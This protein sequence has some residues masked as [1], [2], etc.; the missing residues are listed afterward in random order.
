V[1][2]NFSKKVIIEEIMETL[3]IEKHCFYSINHMPPYLIY[4]FQ[5]LGQTLILKYFTRLK[6]FS[7]I[8]FFLSL[9]LDLLQQILFNY[10]SPLQSFLNVNKILTLKNL[11]FF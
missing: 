4:D 1:I 3:I 7:I 11:L 5:N 9:Y 10:E 8:K 2:V 6:I